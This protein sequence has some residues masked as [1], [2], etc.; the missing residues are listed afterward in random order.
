[1][2]RRLEWGG[3]AGDD[4]GMRRHA[5][6]RGRP[7]IERLEPRALMAGSLPTVSIDAQ[8]DNL[9]DILNFDFNTV[10]EMFQVH[11]SAPSKVPVSWP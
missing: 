4:G 2:A 9:N 7:A 6:R 8:P 5:H 1:M 11:L 10:P 3:F